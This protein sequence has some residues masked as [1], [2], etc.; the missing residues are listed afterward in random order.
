MNPSHNNGEDKPPLNLSTDFSQDRDSLDNTTQALRKTTPSPSAHSGSHCGPTTINAC[1]N[2]E[3]PPYHDK[4]SVQEQGYP[5]DRTL[6]DTSRDVTADRCTTSDQLSGNVKNNRLA[7]PQAP[8]HASVI[9]RHQAP[10]NGS[11]GERT[12]QE[13]ALEGDGNTYPEGGLAAWLVVFGSFSGMVASFGI[14]NSVGTFQAYL[15]THQLANHSPSSI[16]WIFS[17]FAFL[18][19]FCGVQIGP[20]FDAKGPRWLVVAGTIC[21]F[22]GLMGTAESTSMYT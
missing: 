12:T 17:I 1:T 8:D 13:L 5:P 9:F 18:T 14:L 15:S 22:V 7:N 19:F 4:T 21:L 16:G 11:V 6:T 20:F 2:D 3:N 10:S